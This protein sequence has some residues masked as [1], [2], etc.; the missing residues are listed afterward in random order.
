MEKRVN[1]FPMKDMN[2]GRG[3]LHMMD[4]KRDAP[5][6]SCSWKE[7]NFS[8]RIIKNKNFLHFHSNKFFYLPLNTLYYGFFFSI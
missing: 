6:S 4:R 3:P 1:D 5:V 7:S 2:S 8:L